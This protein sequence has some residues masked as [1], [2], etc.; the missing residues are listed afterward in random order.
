MTGPLGRIDWSYMGWLAAALIVL[1]TLFT[2]LLSFLARSH[3]SHV[4]PRHFPPLTVKPAAVR[5]RDRVYKEGEKISV[6]FLIESLLLQAGR[7]QFHQDVVQLSCH[8]G[9]GRR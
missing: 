6:D 4:F 8:R 2:G 9:R 7:R 5:L 3:G 1:T